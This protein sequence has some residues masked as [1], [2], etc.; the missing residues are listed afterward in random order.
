MENSNQL[1][2]VNSYIDKW[3]ENRPDAIAIVQHEDGRKVTY[4]KFSSLIDF[5]ALRLLDMGIKTG[6]VLPPNWYWSRNIWP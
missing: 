5:F 3:A 2:L 4:K 1:P 6:I